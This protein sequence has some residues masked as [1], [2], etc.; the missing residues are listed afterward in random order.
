VTT[1]EMV[2]FDRKQQREG[3]TVFEDNS[4]ILCNF[5]GAESPRGDNKHP[6][7][8]EVRNGRNLSRC[9]STSVVP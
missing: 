1:R 5:R 8:S 4:W 7:S 6:E 3:F 9:H 2:N